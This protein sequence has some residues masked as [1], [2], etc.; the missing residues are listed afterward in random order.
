MKQKSMKQRKVL[1][2]PLMIVLT[3]ILAALPAGFG[4][5]PV[6]VEAASKITFINFLEGTVGNRQQI[7]NGYFWGVENQSNHK[8]YVYYSATVNGRGRYLFQTG[9]WEMPSQLIISDKYV[10]Y[11]QDSA[12]METHSIYRVNLTGTR[13][14]TLVKRFKTAS[15]SETVLKGY[16]GGNFYFWMGALQ[17]GKGGLYR[18]DTSTKKNY[19]C[20]ANVLIFGTEGQYIYLQKYDEDDIWVYDCA[21]N[22]ML[23]KITAPEGATPI[24]Y[25]AD[26][27]A[28]RLIIV[29]DS[30]DFDTR[31]VTTS[32]WDCTLD[33]KNPQFLGEISGL[34]GYLDQ[35]TKDWMY[36][37]VYKEDEEA[38]VLYR[39]EFDTG[40]VLLTRG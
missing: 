35:L 21:A 12:D 19:G 25:V 14:L 30:F 34:N 17:E 29:Y 9:E 31:I 38:D 5:R 6:R 10:W 7:R 4:V 24:R 36:V 37:S 18:Y 20:K 32:A 28:G 3:F 16:Y 1:F 27:D 40:E 8:T 39:L 23:R 2:L 13:K 22:K 11:M 26:E 33:G 15:P